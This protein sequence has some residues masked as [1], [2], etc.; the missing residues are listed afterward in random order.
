M[1]L[2]LLLPLLGLAAS[3]AYLLRPEYIEAMDSR[4]SNRLDLVRQVEADL[5]R[6]MRWEVVVAVTVMAVVALLVQITPAQGVSR[7]HHRPAA[8]TSRPQTRAIFS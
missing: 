3:N 6:R 7:I 2:F 5:N 4:G 8:S 1:K